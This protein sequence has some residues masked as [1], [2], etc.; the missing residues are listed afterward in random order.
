MY[1]KSSLEGS[2]IRAGS[3]ARLV[4]VTQQ[5]QSN[6]AAINPFLID[7]MS[8]LKMTDGRAGSI[9]ALFILDYKVVILPPSWIMAGFPP[10]SAG[11]RPAPHYS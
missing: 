1:C 11:S 7:I 10:A 8:P 2:L 6:T 3:S 9:T 4:D 5:P